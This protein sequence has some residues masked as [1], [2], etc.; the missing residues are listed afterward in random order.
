M[1]R[2]FMFSHPMMRDKFAEYIFPAELKNIKFG[3]MPTNGHLEH[4]E[5][6]QGWEEFAKSNNAEFVF[7][8]NTQRGEV[9]KEEAKKML[10]CNVLM[11]AGGNTFNLLHNLRESGLFNVVKEFVNKQEFV[12][13]GFS[14]GAIIMTPSIAVAGHPAGND[15]DDL[16]DE[17]VPGI[18]DLTGLGIVNF[19]VF[20]HFDPSV[21]QENLANFKKT[22]L[23]EVRPMTDEEFILIDL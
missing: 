18:T 15:P 6:E 7:I 10:S 22:T 13:T 14:A 21:D 8:D 12:F 16:F 17:N 1:R 20:P 4:R 23:N 9:A 11:S 5:F 19:E 3:Y 2:L